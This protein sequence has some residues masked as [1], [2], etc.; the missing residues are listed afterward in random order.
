M[1]QIKNARWILLILL[2]VA[3]FGIHYKEVKAEVIYSQTR[4]ETH[5]DVIGGLQRQK[6]GTGISGYVTSI[7]WK[8][9]GDP[10]A[11]GNNAVNL[12]ECS[13]GTYTSCNLI[14]SSTNFSNSNYL[15]TTTVN[16]NL[17][18]GT[19]R[20][21]TNKYYYFSLSD[22]YAGN[23]MY[24]SNSATSYPNGENLSCGNTYISGCGNNV[25]SLY[26]KLYGATGSTIIYNSTQFTET[27]PGNNYIDPDPEQDFST[28]LY[29]TD[30]DIEAIQN[31][32]GISDGTININANITRLNRIYGGGDYNDTCEIFNY[33][34]EPD[35]IEILTNTIS[36]TTSLTFDGSDPDCVIAQYDTDYKITWN[37]YGRKDIGFG[38]KIWE[39]STTTYFTIGETNA[40]NSGNIQTYIASSTALQ[41]K[42]EQT[43]GFN[44]ETCNPVA[45]TNFDMADCIVQLIFPNDGF[46]EKKLTEEWSLFQYAFPIGFITDF[47][48]IIST[49]TIGTLTPINAELPSALGVGTPSITLDLTGVLDSLLN[50]TTS[51]FTNVSAPDTRTFY[52]ITSEYWNKLVYIAFV[53]YIITRILGSGFGPNWGTSATSSTTT[54]EKR[55]LG[56]GVKEIH[57]STKTKYKGNKFKI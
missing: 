3:N 39:T 7:E 31:L 38:S 35:E 26:F 30:N 27:T 11:T 19:P 18:N 54:I 34:Y 8:W 15:G 9:W 2:I 51:E 57:T 32:W 49:T 43:F 16:I 40:S 24:G 56:G 25:Y 20:L 55:N 45:L 48:S 6:L 29:I 28:T 17:N 53:M 13:D 36:T 52:E 41:I 10:L 14:A 22:V 21:E 42:E 44:F 5:T 46:I 33:E 37:A 1:K 50:A 4:T 47:L 12:Y 23:K